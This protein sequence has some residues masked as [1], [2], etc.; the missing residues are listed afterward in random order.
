M[1]RIGILLPFLAVASASAQR[2]PVADAHQHLL[3]PAIAQLLGVPAASASG[4]DASA[5]IAL[6]D[7]AHIQRAVLLSV[8]YM[9]GSPRRTIVDEYTKVRAENDW[10]AAQAAL[11]PERLVA[12]C[13]F[14]P[15][16]PYALEEVD[17][18][19]ADARLHRGIKLHFGNSDVQLD[20]P[21]HVRQLQRVFQAANEHGMAIVVHMRASIDRQRPYGPAEAHTFLE[22][23]LP[24]APD[25]PVQVAH[26]AGAGPGYN[27]PAADSVMALLAEAVER[28]DP[29]TAH[30][31]FDVASLADLTISSQQ[32]ALL[33]E[34]I[35]RVGVERVLYGSDAAFGNNLRPREGWEA[36]TRLPLTDLELTTIA[37]NLPPYFK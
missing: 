16:K 29:A 21:E 22:Q 23:V 8:A 13:S 32:A 33:V 31:W 5:L 28:H 18:C 14:N 30:L 37:G 20:N 34:R 2:P 3:S 27:D 35:R 15:L 25:V 6:L 36:F 26:F 7:S 17:R 10:T 1:G 19:A 12:L 4:P 9:Y 11:Y 24:Y